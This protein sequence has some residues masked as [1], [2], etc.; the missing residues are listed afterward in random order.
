MGSTALPKDFPP[1]IHEPTLTW[2]KDD[3]EQSVDWE[4]QS[5]HL[6]FLITSGLHSSKYK[7]AILNPIYF[8]LHV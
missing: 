8:F 1:G 7:T 2:F 4:V 3:A 5:K 6:E